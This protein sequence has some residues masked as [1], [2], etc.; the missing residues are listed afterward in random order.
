MDTYGA[1]NNSEHIEDLSLTLSSQF[2]P[3]VRLDSV[4]S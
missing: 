2:E 4:S 1:T 3:V